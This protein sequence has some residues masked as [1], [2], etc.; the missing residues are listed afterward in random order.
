MQDTRDTFYQD[1]NYFNRNFNH[2]KIFDIQKGKIGVN[3][4]VDKAFYTFFAVSILLIITFSVEPNVW[5]L[6]GVAI[7]WA[8]TLGITNFLE[9]FFIRKKLKKKGLPISVF[10]YKWKCE[11]LDDVRI[12]KICK[13]YKKV[14]SDVILKR[15]EL[16]EKLIEKYSKIPNYGILKI[17]EFFGKQYFLITIAILLFILKEK[18]D[19]E[20]LN[21]FYKGFFLFISLGIIIS[22]SIKTIEK[23]LFFDNYDVKV[24]SLED[25][26]FVLKNIL[27][28]RASKSNS[29]N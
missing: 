3:K 7:L 6:L 5:F 15:I 1:F 8:A 17:M 20:H 21:Q 11:E 12:L 14:S 23:K 13:K 24:K 9:V 4:L 19:K 29:N 16:S 27:L 18:F 28:I 10:F 26:V 25:Y 2:K 22:I